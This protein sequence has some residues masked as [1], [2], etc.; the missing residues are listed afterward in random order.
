MVVFTVVW[1]GSGGRGDGVG[2]GGVRVVVA[3]MGGLVELLEL[4]FLENFPPLA[5]TLGSTAGDF[6]G[7]LLPLVAVLGLKRNDQVLLL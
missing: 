2:G 5:E 7:D 3:E 1:G 4:L 6:R